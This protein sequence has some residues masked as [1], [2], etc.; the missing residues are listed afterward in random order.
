MLVGKHY[1]VD[2]V[3]V[4]MLMIIMTLIEHV[5]LTKDFLL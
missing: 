5:L 1:D 4:L 2:Y 3:G